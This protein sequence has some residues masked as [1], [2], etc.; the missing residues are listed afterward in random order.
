M[1]DLKT[2]PSAVYLDL[3]WNCADLPRPGVSDPEIVEIGLVALDPASLRLVREANYL[4]RPR[5]LV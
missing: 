4:V 2:L 1:Q 5:Q 3:E